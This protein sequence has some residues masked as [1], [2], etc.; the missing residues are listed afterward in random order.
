MVG[1]SSKLTRA[2]PPV[3]SH[4]SDSSLPDV[5]SLWPS[6]LA[7]LLAGASFAV[8]LAGCAPK[9]RPV[10]FLEQEWDS[11]VAM[12]ACQA[13]DDRDF[14]NEYLAAVEDFEHQ[15]TTQTQVSPA[16]SGIEFKKI[17]STV[18]RTQFEDAHTGRP[19]WV[20]QITLTG[21]GAPQQWNLFPRI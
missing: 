1:T 16:C 14:M 18:E 21:P 2:A 12:A 20:L 3:R 15:V 7:A 17:A 10:V 8:W 4:F 6:W 11:A 13:R 5:E 9:V 19:L